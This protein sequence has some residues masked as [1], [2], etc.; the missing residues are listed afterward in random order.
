MQRSP[1]DDF[2]FTRNLSFSL[3]AAIDLVCMCYRMICW[4][5]SG[6]KNTPAWSNR[7][8]MI[9]G[10]REKEMWRKKCKRRNFY[11]RISCGTSAWCWV[12]GV[13]CSW[14]L[15]EWKLFW[16]HFHTVLWLRMTKLFNK[17]RLQLF[18]LY[19]GN[20]RRIKNRK[21]IFFLTGIIRMNGKWKNIFWIFREIWR[22]FKIY[23]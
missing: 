14:D 1:A 23:G 10:N 13:I 3:D 18:L 12:R 21:L 7:Q 22:K 19:F 20:L 17:N 6:D 9:W 8:T 2:F 5:V 16:W 11:F 4:S 15:K